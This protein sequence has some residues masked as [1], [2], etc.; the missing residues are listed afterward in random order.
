MPEL[1]GWVTELRLDN[2]YDGQDSPVV[3]SRGLRVV[4]WARWV[5]D[6][7]E[8]ELSF[9]RSSSGIVQAELG[10]SYFWSWNRA[11]SRMFVAA[12]G[13]TSFEYEPLLPDQFSL[14]K[15][16]RLDAF[17][18]GERRGDHYAALT[19]GYLHSV[20]RLPDFV[21]G[22]ILAGAWVEQGS[23]FDDSSS[24]E[25][26][27]QLSAGVI[28]ETL[29]GPAWIGYSLG[30]SARGLIVGIGRLWM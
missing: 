3:P 1:D 17:A 29:L 4:G 8:T 5:F 21:G 6:A 19:V 28:A 24:A 25:Y 15:P 2:V 27:A 14:G 22:P 11:V 20:L 26:E 7:P 18:E 23:A 30:T 13:G 9:D 16:M 12:S 10:G